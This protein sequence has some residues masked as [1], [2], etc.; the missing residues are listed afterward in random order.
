MS[1]LT[2]LQ[3]KSVLVVGL[4]KSGL[5]VARYL[6]RHAV[7]FAVADNRQ[8]P[9]GIAEIRTR[10]PDVRV[11]NEFDAE[12][13]GGFDVLVVS[14]GLSLDEPAIKAALKKGRQVIGD[15]ELFAWSVTRPVVSVTGSNGKSTVVAMLGAMAEASGVKA[16]VCGNFGDPALDSLDDAAISLYILEL[17]SFQL[18]TTDSLK[19]QVACIL[20]ISEDHMDRY[21]SMAEYIAAKQKVFDNASC[22]VINHDDRKTWPVKNSA[23]RETVFFTNGVPERGDM[24]GISLIDGQTCLMLGE[25]RLM[26]V[27]DLKVVGRHN[28]L[29]ALAALA[30]G[31]QAG[32]AIKDMIAALK[33]F[34]GLPH[35][36]QFVS[37]SNGVR[38][39][40][41]SKGTNVDAT[42]QA[43][44]GLNAPVILIAGGVGKG[45]DFSP[46][47]VVANQHIK[48][49]VLI[50]RDAALIAEV[51]GRTGV[52][53][54]FA[55]TMAE[56][57]ENAA[58]L[59]VAGDVVLLSPACASFDMFKNFEERGDIFVREVMRE[60][61]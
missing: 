9:P 31:R 60:V 8:N 47:G 38:W 59:A 26:P 30:I 56:A 46:L 28:A 51:L 5:S 20:N 24:F 53:V 42:V 37:E 41:D 34:N 3:N 16:K 11:F 57:V 21:T 15:I 52:P 50:G 6:N 55:S 7:P 54:M 13:F 17:S 1:T 39:I 22:L 36:V 44:K 35:R 10:F 61:A 58:S 18:E 23:V 2:E 45:A 40:N 48:A 4:G 25:E 14:P 29:N 27:S 19:S 12:V 43:V 33:V 32:L 49:A